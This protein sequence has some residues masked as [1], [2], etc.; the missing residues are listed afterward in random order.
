MEGV[1]GCHSIPPGPISYEIVTPW[2]FTENV[3]IVVARVE[4]AGSVK[5]ANV[6]L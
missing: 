3:D 5:G 6:S 2:G 4:N 1:T